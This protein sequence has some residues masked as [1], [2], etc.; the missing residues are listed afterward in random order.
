MIRLLLAAV[1]LFA[2]TPVCPAQSE[3]D[4]VPASATTATTTPRV[5]E[6]EA[7]GYQFGVDDATPFLEEAEGEP[8]TIAAA[9]AAPWPDTAEGLVELARHGRPVWLK[10][11]LHNNYP[12]ARSWVLWF[13]SSGLHDRVDFYWVV[14]GV[15]K[16]Q[17]STGASVP[18]EKRRLK[19]RQQGVTIAIEPDERGEIYARVD[20]G[21]PVRND[22]RIRPIER[23]SADDG[24]ETVFFGFYFGVLVFVAI[25]GAAMAVTVRDSAFL[26]YSFQAASMV[27]IVFVTAG[28][29][30]QLLPAN[31]AKL[32]PA[33]S[34]PLMALPTLVSTLFLPAFLRL[35]KLAPRLARACYALLIPAAINLGIQVAA[36]LTPSLRDAGD[37]AMP[38]NALISVVA[39]LTIGAI[40]AARRIPD[41]VWYLF[42]LLLVIAASV[43]YF[44][45]IG[46]ALPL[47]YLS[48]GLMYV[49][50]LTNAIIVGVAMVRRLRGIQDEAVRAR[51]VDEERQRLR[52]LL[53]V[54]G[55]DLSNSATAVMGYARFGKTSFEG[56]A[57]LVFER[58]LKV[59]SSQEA[60]IARVK[61]MRAVADGKQELALVPVSLGSVLSELRETFDAQLK[62]KG[63]TLVCDDA[64]ATGV[65]VMGERASLVHSVLGNVLGNAIKF[66][67]RGATIALRVRPR[68][69]GKI[70]VEIEDHGIGMPPAI[71][72]HLFEAEAEASRPGTD[73]ERGTGYGLQLV[74][75]FMEHFGGQITVE[76]R[77]GG[78]GRGPSGTVVR[79]A[80]T[81]AGI[82]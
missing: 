10:V 71:V 24:A 20:S 17:G 54:L 61:A 57:S 73:G 3:S 14:N 7:R 12:E 59:A 47:S 50:N 49:G 30:E 22:L 34:R 55:H 78:E 38:L 82:R 72:D 46:G 44:L 81:D 66:S 19:R 63:L 56:D 69:A 64:S 79:L 5:I 27:C 23:Y 68:G 48:M 2:S 37:A 8:L 29:W 42:A 16:E 62:A 45:A 58:I 74:R 41:S 28:F 1:I 18:F 65:E 52:A 39:L 31:L 43:P 51:A 11:A 70:V 33:L 60:L 36:S 25:L 6:L 53:R 75:A 40:A 76:S 26:F 35:P 80:F 9:I 32:A 15:V 21:F 4:G 67:P 77:S 13:F